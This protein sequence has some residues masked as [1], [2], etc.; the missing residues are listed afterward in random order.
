[1]AFVFS[2]AAARRYLRDRRVCRHR[3]RSA[4]DGLRQIDV[5]LGRWAWR[6]F[7]PVWYPTPSLVQHIGEVSTLWL[8]CRAAGPRAASQV[9]GTPRPEAPPSGGVYPA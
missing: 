1:V 6:R 7:V 8:S 5:L 4:A 2:P 3:W 9:V